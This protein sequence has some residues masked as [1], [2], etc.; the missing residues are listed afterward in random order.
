MVGGHVKFDKEIDPKLAAAA[1]DRKNVVFVHGG[2]AF[3]I[4]IDEIDTNMVELACNDKGCA[5]IAVDSDPT[6]DIDPSTVKH[7]NS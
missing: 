3:L 6:N 4:P 2:A 7:G 1:Y 5:L